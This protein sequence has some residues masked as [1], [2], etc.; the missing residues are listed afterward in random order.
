MSKNQS[1]L[2]RSRTVRSAT[3]KATARKSKRAQA[4]LGTKAS[5]TTTPTPLIKITS[6]SRSSPMLPCTLTV[7][8]SCRVSL[9][10]SPGAYLMD[11]GST[12]VD[13]S[14]ASGPGSDPSNPQWTFNLT[15]SGKTYAVEVFI[16]DSTG[17]V[18]VCDSQTIST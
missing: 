15:A 12:P 17:A 18:L 1:T 13:L 11:T 10:Q 14:P 8:A 5:A 3:R 2:T 4:A 7:T 9:D 16:T 6:V